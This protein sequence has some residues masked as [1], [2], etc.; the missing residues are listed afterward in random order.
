M[1]LNWINNSF[2]FCKTYY[3][4]YYFSVTLFN[5][6]IGTDTHT[7]EVIIIIILSSQTIQKLS[8]SMDGKQN[9]FMNQFNK[10][11]FLTVLVVSGKT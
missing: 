10:T 11:S 2:L 8:L 7:H 3:S 1:K 5:Q 9:E 6:K 4:V